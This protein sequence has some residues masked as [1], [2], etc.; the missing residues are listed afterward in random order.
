MHTLRT[1]AGELAYTDT[2]SGPAVVLLHA[3]L[4]DHHDFN[5]IIPALEASRR[6]IAVD[7]PGHGAAAPN[8]SV[9]AVGFADALAELTTALDL[10]QAVYLGNSVGAFTAARLAIDHPDR[11]AGLSLVNGGGLIPRSLLTRAFY[12]VYGSSVFAR[13]LLPRSIRAYM[14]PMSP[15][16][17][18]VVD[19]V[20]RNARTEVG[21][22]TYSSLWRSFATPGYDLTPHA[23]KI[24][25]PTLIVWDSLDP[26]ARLHYGKQAHHRIL[27][28]ELRILPTGHLPFSS[29]PTD[30][31]EIV[32]PFIESALTLR[33]NAR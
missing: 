18:A 30:F 31:L 23:A 11:V 20:T 3:N 13:H 10:K 5:P 7:W 6:V 14:R 21:R 12:R 26:I 25:A 28:S 9:T 24:T 32:L 29:A 27:G 17:E 19:R 8:T 2:G 15:H 1:T 4:H 22:A 33:D 16:D